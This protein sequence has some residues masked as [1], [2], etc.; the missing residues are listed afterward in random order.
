[1]DLTFS[2]A[3][4]T[5][6]RTFTIRSNA[7]ACKSISSFSNSGESPRPTGADPPRG[8]GLEVVENFWTERED[9]EI[10][11]FSEALAVAGRLRGR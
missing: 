2:R 6:A 5:S 3:R 9:E 1:M 7:A 11:I 8:K 4:S 10:P